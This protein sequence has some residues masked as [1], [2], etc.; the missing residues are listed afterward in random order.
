M[1]PLEI[2]RD[3]LDYNLG[4]IGPKRIAVLE[5]YV[6]VCCPDLATVFCAQVCILSG[7]SEGNSVYVAELLGFVIRD[8]PII[9]L[10]GPIGSVLLLK[11]REHLIPISCAEF[12]GDFSYQAFVK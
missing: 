2:S 8:R 6:E 12:D 5:A 9:A 10:D 3:Q 7:M 1:P 4:L 11:N